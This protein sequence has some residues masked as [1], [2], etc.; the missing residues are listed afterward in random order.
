MVIIMK[1][2]KTPEER[3]QELIIGRLMFGFI[4]ATI[5]Y[6]IFEGAL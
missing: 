3:R 4:I 1:R 6:K 5:I 2:Q